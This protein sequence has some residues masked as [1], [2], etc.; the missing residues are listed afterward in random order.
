[1]K[2]NRNFLIRSDCPDNLCCGRLGTL[3][4][5]GSEKT[6]RYWAII[7]VMMM[8]RDG[9]LHV[10]SALQNGSPAAAAAAEAADQGTINAMLLISEL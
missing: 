8:M 7:T 9:D 1:M 6:G 5:L 10:Y 3:L 4:D 2:R